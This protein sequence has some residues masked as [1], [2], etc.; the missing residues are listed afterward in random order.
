M[1]GQHVGD[2]S[3]DDDEY[4]YDES[5]DIEEDSSSSPPAQD[6]TT[7]SEPVGFVPASPEEPKKDASKGNAYQALFGS[8]APRN[9][10]RMN[11]TSVT[12]P[13]E[14]LTAANFS[15]ASLGMFEMI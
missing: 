4:G 6:N 1:T 10:P 2:E 12:N 7:A 11:L 13:G 8:P 14:T 15:L 3:Y 5:Y 9:I